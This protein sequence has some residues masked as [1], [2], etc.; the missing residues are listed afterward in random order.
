LFTLGALILLS[1][2]LSITEE[3]ILA[4]PGRSVLDLIFEASSAFN[5]VGLSTGITAQLSDAGKV[6]I[7]L[8]MFIGRIG[9]LT[10][11]FAIGGRLV[12]NHFKYPEGH[13]MVG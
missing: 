7:I 12:S 8:A 9:T 4:Q 13:T 2:L 11:A 6:I 5:T 3:A 10:I 1:I